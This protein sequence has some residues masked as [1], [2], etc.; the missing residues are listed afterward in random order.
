M[1]KVTS[2]IP[3]Y[4]LYYQQLKTNI[5]DFVSGFYSH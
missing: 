3:V 2:C 5:L 4:Y 1:Q